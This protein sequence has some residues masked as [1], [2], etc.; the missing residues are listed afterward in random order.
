L[1]G[2]VTRV[3][4]INPHTLFYVDVKGENGGVVNWAFETAPPSALILRGWQKD[5]LKV[6]DTITVHTYRAKDGT[7]F[8]TARQVTLADGR[9]V[10]GGS[11]EDKGPPE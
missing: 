2:V 9:T 5:S 8:G 6:G 3:E 7:N 10:F 4:W 11:M 1:A